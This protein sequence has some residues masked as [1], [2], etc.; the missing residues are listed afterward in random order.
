MSNLYELEVA[1]NA[2]GG[3]LA[4]LGLKDGDSCYRIAGPKAWGGAKT[5]AKLDISEADLITFIKEFAPDVAAHFAKER[6][7]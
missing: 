2:E 3:K 1:V 5:L 4:Y 6:H 7:A